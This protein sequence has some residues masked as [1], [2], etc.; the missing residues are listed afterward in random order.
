VARARAWALVDHARGRYG[1]P[2]RRFLDR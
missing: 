1:P 2:P